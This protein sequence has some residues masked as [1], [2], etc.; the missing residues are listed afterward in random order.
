MTEKELK[1][2]K[3]FAANNWCKSEKEQIFADDPEYAV[4]NPW[5]DHTGRFTLSD[6]DAVEEW[7]LSVV[8]DF[9]EKAKEELEKEQKY[10][11]TH[12]VLCG[13]VWCH[14]NK[15][16]SVHEVQIKKEDQEEIE[17]ILS[18]YETEGSSERNCYDRKFSDV[19]AEEY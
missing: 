2:I 1:K 10:K 16:F 19:F 17:K 13:F 6:Y 7:G 8:L 18:K 3:E 9:C 4:T 14:G 11:E 12:P 5:I 15:D